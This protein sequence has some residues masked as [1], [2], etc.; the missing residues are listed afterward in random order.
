MPA[1]PYLPAPQPIN[2]IQWTGDNATEVQ[3]MLSADIGTHRYLNYYVDFAGN[4]LLIVDTAEMCNVP[5]NWYV[6]FDQAKGEVI[7]FDP[8]TFEQR[9]APV[10]NSIDQ[11]NE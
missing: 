7:S 10:D 3:S 6:G 2:F 11:E 4:N 1:T 8:A 5:L 9:W